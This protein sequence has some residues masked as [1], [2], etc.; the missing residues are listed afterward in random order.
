[1]DRNNRHHS[2]YHLLF[3]HVVFGVFSTFPPLSWPFLAS[4]SSP[5]VRLCYLL[6]VIVLAF[7]PRQQTCKAGPYSSRLHSTLCCVC[8]VCVYH[9]HVFIHAG[10]FI[11]RFIS[12]TKKPRRDETHEHTFLPDNFS[13][14]FPIQATFFK[15]SRDIFRNFS[16]LSFLSL[17]CQ[18]HRIKVMNNQPEDIYKLTNIWLTLPPL[19]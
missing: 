13:D 4:S 8:C 2:V 15:N 12:P 3:V 6:L 19:V 14:S 18:E 16:F 9:I 17:C 10:V 7:S 5:T 1:M 11:F